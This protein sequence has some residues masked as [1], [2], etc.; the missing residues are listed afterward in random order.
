M[1][2]AN[3]HRAFLHAAK[4]AAESNSSENRGAILRQLTHA[5]RTLN[6][7]DPIRQLSTVPEVPEPKPDD[8]KPFLGSW[9]PHDSDRSHWWTNTKVKATTGILLAWEIAPFQGVILWK[10]PQWKRRTS[11]L[12]L[13]FHPTSVFKCSGHYDTKH[14]FWQG[15]VWGPWQEFTS[16]RS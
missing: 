11:K 10:T 9:S 2:T 4:E 3:Q 15:V 13:F 8:L 6:A 16:P 5:E 1:G 14:L 12:S 7:L